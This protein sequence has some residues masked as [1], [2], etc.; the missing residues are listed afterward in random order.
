MPFLHRILSLL[1]LVVA[2][3]GFPECTTW[4]S[5]PRTILLATDA[6]ND[7]AVILAG[8]LDRHPCI[9]FPSKDVQ[10]AASLPTLLSNHDR[11]RNVSLVGAI[12]PVQK[13]LGLK[14]VHSEVSIDFVI[15]IIRH[16]LFQAIH[17][18][19]GDS[20]ST[21]RAATALS[22]NRGVENLLEQA[23]VGSPTNFDTGRYSQSTSYDQPSQVNRM[24][25]KLLP[26][27][28][29]R[30][31]YCRVMCAMETS[32][33]MKMP[34]SSLSVSFPALNDLYTNLLGVRYS[35]S[36]S[37]VCDTLNGLRV[38]SKSEVE[39]FAQ[40]TSSSTWSSLLSGM[41]PSSS[42]WANA[43]RF[44]ECK[45][46]Q[47]TLMSPHLFHAPIVSHA[48][49][50]ES[51]GEDTSTE[52][53]YDIRTVANA[54]S[55]VL[56]LELAWRAVLLNSF[57]S[58]KILRAHVRFHLI[59]QF[60]S[61]VQSGSYPPS[62]LLSFVDQSLARTKYM[63]DMKHIDWARAILNRNSTTKVGYTPSPNVAHSSTASDLCAAYVRSSVDGTA[64]LPPEQV[65]WTD[66]ASS[67]LITF[68]DLF[69]NLPEV[70]VLQEALLKSVSSAS[71]MDFNRQRR[72][73]R[74][75]HSPS[76]KLP[77]PQAQPGPTHHGTARIA[78]CMV[79]VGQ[80]LLT[81]P[82][83]AASMRQN[84]INS[85]G[86]AG[87]RDGESSTSGGPDVFVVLVK[88]DSKSDEARLQEQVMLHFEPVSFEW[89]NKSAG[90]DFLCHTTSVHQYPKIPQGTKAVANEHHSNQ[91]RQWAQCMDSIIKHE[92][93]MTSKRIRKSNIRVNHEREPIKK[94]LHDIF[95]YDI[96][97]KARPDDIWFGPILPWC[98]FHRDIAYISRQVRTV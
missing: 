26:P 78:I 82:G 29:L 10:S 87:S 84:F 32:V 31:D 60:Q 96:I 98:S 66:A 21:L 4:P 12:V 13:L 64:G 95:R 94:S 59:R 43:Q 86:G 2:G 7:G 71:V 62:A 61:I 70:L 28:L 36:D 74:A 25:P 69:G 35:N 15:L 8:L 44:G 56:P 50:V 16:P 23:S 1:S 17:K 20:Y 49:I 76:R 9:S 55:P 48:A 93:L 89:H 27:K 45:F 83:H 39:R 54:L 6:R 88:P 92:L 51:D 40:G 37:A 67:S 5:G 38:V 57:T 81:R 72:M 80:V 34:S 85:Y 22:Q 68:N 24:A 30:L 42:A 63:K 75:H 52:A 41:K 18:S 73:L 77:P 97:I 46:E 79:G 90:I 58:S 47:S 3:V 14:S 19:I 65:D 53:A 11:L 33:T 91:L